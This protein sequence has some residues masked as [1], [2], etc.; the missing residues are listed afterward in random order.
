M[1]LFVATEC[2][3]TLVSVVYACIWLVRLGGLVRGAARTVLM[4]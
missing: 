3:G 1:C 4:A 2:T